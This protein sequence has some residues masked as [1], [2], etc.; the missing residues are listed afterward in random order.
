MT[1]AI[2]TSVLLGVVR[3]AAHPAQSAPADAGFV[4]SGAV[5]I[6][7]NGSFTRDGRGGCAGAGQYADL[8]NGAP[9]VIAGDEPPMATGQLADGRALT[10]GTC[11]FWFSVP[12][13]PARQDGYR[14]MVVGRD[15]GAYTEAA[16]KGTLVTVRL[17]S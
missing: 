3:H 12:K 6:A 1:G 10:D 2:A 11:R 14:L 15:G 17:G 4:V 9:V 13:V 7:G 16:L 8:R 5:S